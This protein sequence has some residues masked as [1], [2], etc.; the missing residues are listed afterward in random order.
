MKQIFIAGAGLSSTSLIQYLLGQSE[1]NNW[2]IVV[3]DYDISLAQQR[4]ENHSNG[5][6]IA[7]DV[8]DPEQRNDAIMQSDIV[9]SMLPSSMHI[10][11]AEDCVIQGVNM[12]TASYVSDD[13]AALH[14]KAIEKGV[15]LLNEMGLDPG[16]DHMSA[17]KIIDHIHQQDGEIELFKSFCGGLV[18]KEFDNNPWNYKFTWNPRNVVLAGQQTAQF[19]R[20]GLLKY[21]P[22][23]QLFSRL[24]YIE[25]D[26]EGQFECYAN[27][28]SLVYQSHYEL[29]HTPTILRGT[30]RRP[31]FCKAWDVFVQLGM[32]DD[33]FE[34]L[35]LDTMTWREFTNSF[36]IFDNK[37]SVEE[38]LK[39]YLSLD[40]DVME[41][42][43]WLGIFSNETIG[44]SKG[45]PAQVLQHLLEPKWR[46]EEGDKDMIVM[47]HIFDYK[48]NG[49]SHTLHSSLVVKGKDKTHTAMSMTV[50]LPV[51]IATELIL[52]GRI[53]L[54]GVHIPVQSE[55]YTPVLDRL[56][57]FDIDFVEKVYTNV[58]E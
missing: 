9:V 23:N 19:K 16:I 24:E 13:I 56:K 3:G 17:K 12:V 40:D 11:L 2:N 34:M 32:T 26:N 58:A 8:F 5:R 10:L 49:S 39:T 33:S 52:Q 55:I 28:D 22:Y 50:G 46:L 18:S 47:Q 1:K 48:L 41:K 42:L 43:N 14:E 31:G 51:A 15:L 4:I 29:K 20:N 7:F 37:K 30:L 44:L 57:D 36:L 27:R 25:I 53:T 21:I 35:H 45:S 38:K 6:A 54:K